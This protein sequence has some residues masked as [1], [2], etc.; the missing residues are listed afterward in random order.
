MAIHTLIAFV[1]SLEDVTAGMGLDVVA[2]SLQD[3]AAVEA[4]QAVVI[5]DGP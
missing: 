5:A 3:F 1:V 4:G 2:V